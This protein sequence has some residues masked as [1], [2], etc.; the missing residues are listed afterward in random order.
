[1]TNRSAVLVSLLLFLSL[2]VLAQEPPPALSMEMSE[3][4]VI[5]TEVASD[6][7]TVVGLDAARRAVTS[8]GPASAEAFRYANTTSMEQFV[9]RFGN[10][11]Y[12][13][14]A[15]EGVTAV[16]TDHTGIS[17]WSEVFATDASGKVV[18]HGVDWES[19]SVHAFAAEMGIPLPFPDRLEIAFNG[20]KQI[21]SVKVYTLQDAYTAPVEPTPQMR[22]NNYGIT[23]FE[24]QYWFDTPSVKKW[25][26]VPNGVVVEN[27]NVMRTISFPAVTT[28]KV[29]VLVKKAVDTWSR[30]TEVE[31]F[32]T[33][34]VNVALQANGGV[35]TASSTHSA[36]FAPSGAINGDRKGY[37]WGSGGGWNDGTPTTVRLAAG[38]VTETTDPY[39]RYITIQNPFA[40]V[41][42]SINLTPPPTTPP[43]AGSP[44]LFG[45]E[46]T[47]AKGKIFRAQLALTNRGREIWDN[48]GGSQLFGHDWAQRMIWVADAND[49]VIKIVR[50]SAGRIT[51]LYLGETAAI[52]FLYDA[53]GLVSKEFVDLRTNMSLYRVKRPGD[54]ERSKFPRTRQ[55]LQAVLPG[56]GTIAELDKTLGDSGYVVASLFDQPYALIPFVNNGP[57]YD[58]HMPVRWIIT[59]YPEDAV[60]DLVDRIEYNDEEIVVHMSTWRE[61]T[62][63]A[64]HTVAFSI[65]RKWSSTKPTTFRE[66]ASYTPAV[67]EMFVSVSDGSAESNEPDNDDVYPCGT[68]D[69][70]DV[71]APKPK[72]PKL[73]NSPYWPPPGGGGG[74]SGQ[75]DPFDRR[76]LQGMPLQKTETAR[77]QAVEKLQQKPDC[78]PLF[79]KLQ[80]GAGVPGVDPSWETALKRVTNITSG[81]GRYNSLR[82]APCRN[83]DV[84]MWMKSIRTGTIYVCRSVENASQF[85]V[86][87]AFIHELLHAAG[88]REKES[89]PTGTATLSH[90][91]ITQ[92]VNAACN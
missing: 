79:Q 31:V 25:V 18:L 63:T 27:R 14:R 82:Q 26:V 73:P 3:Q 40:K 36:G 23:D 58:W 61:L 43:R 55:A 24:V 70:I 92:A 47:E 28:T 51:L 87:N 50:D 12:Q 77:Q 78:A 2:N 45:S 59:L 10:R 33:A 39:Y 42:K 37:P 34:G 75:Q 41:R 64:R 17:P 57:I 52:E 13:T 60:H 54:V 74:G 38:T 6:G 68:G 35:A 9:D 21:S 83:P 7:V 29:R 88:L 48:Q 19:S 11:V 85:D 62:G 86:T 84:L 80:N 76:S 16:T 32:N 65:P 90:G 71:K 81:D 15:A 56:H 89:S 67:A 4:A 44:Y 72:E 91:E 1:M 5:E 46:E 22:F 20:A 49:Y 8:W 69:C 30:I 66:D 53:K